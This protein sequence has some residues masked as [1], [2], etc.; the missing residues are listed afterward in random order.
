MSLIRKIWNSSLF[1]ISSLNSFSVFLKIATGIVSAKVLAIFVGPAGMALVGNMRNFVSVFESFSTL[2]FQ[3]GVIRFVAS[4]KKEPEKVKSF[5][6]TVLV[7]LFGVSLLLGLL[8]YFLSDYWVSFLFEQDSIYILVIK[9]FAFTLPWQTLSLFMLSVLNGLGEYKKVIYTNIAGH[10][11]ALG[12]TVFFVTRLYTLGAL[13]SIIISPAL[14][15][16]VT[17]FFLNKEIPIFRGLH[18]KLFDL[19]LLNHLYSFTVMTLFTAILSPLVFLIL[20]NRLI[21]VSGL[22]EAGYWETMSRLSTYYIMFVSTLLTVYFLPQLSQSQTVSETRSIFRKYYKSVLPVF[23]VLM[24]FLFF[25][26]S[27]LVELLFS[28]EFLPVTDLFVWQLAGDTLKVASLILGYEFFAKKLTKAYLAAEAM[29]FA[30]LFISGWFL[31]DIFG[32]KGMV[33]AHLITYTVYFLV[34]LFYFR[35]KV[36]K[37]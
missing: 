35:D 18:P 21:D 1:R 8:L 2:G 16:L 31:I 26:R 23:V 28:R 12:I 32:A 13:L 15:L 5:L 24:I 14:L 33:I 3:N 6:T 7:L 36:F 11:L 9:V 34:L 29:S 27:F 37:V 17:F 19:K 4:H 10:L 30:V 22:S 20:R 25:G